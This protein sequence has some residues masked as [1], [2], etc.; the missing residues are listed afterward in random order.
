M[1]PGRKW[2]DSTLNEGANELEAR[3]LF[4][5]RSSKLLDLVHQGLHDL[6]FLIGQLVRPRSP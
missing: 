2:L 4:L 5:R 6:H 3:Y 1:G